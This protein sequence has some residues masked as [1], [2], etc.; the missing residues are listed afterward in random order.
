MQQ[1]PFYKSTK[2]VYYKSS[3]VDRVFPPSPMFIKSKRPKFTICQVKASFPR[4]VSN[5]LLLPI[6]HFLC[7]L[8]LPFACQVTV[9]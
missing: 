1:K 3:L 4:K 9:I 2:K 7:N 5:H 6:S 8:C